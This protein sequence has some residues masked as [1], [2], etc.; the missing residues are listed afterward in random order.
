MLFESVHEKNF[1]FNC[2][3]CGKNFT[4][5]FMNQTKY[6]IEITNYSCSWK[7]KDSILINVVKILLE[8]AIWMIMKLIHELNCEHLLFWI[9]TYILFFCTIVFSWKCF[10]SYFTVVFYVQFCL[11]VFY[12]RCFL[13][14]YFFSM[15]FIVDTPL[16]LVELFL[17]KLVRTYTQVRTKLG[18][19]VKMQQT[20]HRQQTV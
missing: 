10:M 2:D 12:S 5:A 1:E 4:K 18:S 7:W 11:G 6:W 9:W 20:V 13:S 17:R 3:H 16:F 14:R 8:D 19:T 15:C